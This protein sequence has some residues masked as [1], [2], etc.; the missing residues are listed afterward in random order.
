MSITYTI[1]G[2]TL[3]DQLN[4]ATM[5][6]LPD[7]N[8]ND[9]CVAASIAEALHILTGR[10]FDGDELKD[11]VYGQGYVGFQS[12]ARYVAYCAALGVQLAPINASQ[13]GLIAEI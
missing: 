12:A 11:A 1:P 7:E 8:A 13:A 2:A 10:T 5:D 9:N 4:E 3:L 6:G